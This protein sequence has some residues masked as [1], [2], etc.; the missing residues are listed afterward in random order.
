MQFK[1]HQEEGTVKSIQNLACSSTA[2]PPPCPHFIKERVKSRRALVP[3]VS[4]LNAAGSLAKLQ[5]GASFR[6]V[7]GASPI[8]RATEATSLWQ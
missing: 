2:S 8:A 7:L 4:G 3:D 1:E 6:I 5:G